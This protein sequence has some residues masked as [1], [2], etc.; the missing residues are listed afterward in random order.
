MLKPTPATIV[1]TW[2]FNGRTEPSPAP[3]PSAHPDLVQDSWEGGRWVKYLCRWDAASE[4][5]LRV[6][7]VS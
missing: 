1:N 3:E 5:Y 2:S 7:V 4:R 6:E